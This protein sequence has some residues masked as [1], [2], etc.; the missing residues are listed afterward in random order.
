MKKIVVLGST[1]S[2]GINVLKVVERFPQQFSVVALSALNNTDLLARQIRQFKPRYAAIDAK[3]ICDLRRK[4]SGSKVSLFDT[5][6]EIDHLASLPQADIVVLGIEGSAALSPFLAAIRSGKHIAPANKEA[7]VMAGSVLMAEAKKYKA[8]IVP[9]DSEQS[10]IF[11][12]LQGQDRQGL[13]RVYLTASGGPLRCVSRDQLKRVSVADVLKHPRWRMGRKITVDSATLMNKG[14][15]VIEA[16]WLFDL[17]ASHIEVLIHPESIIHSMVEF[18][19]GAVMAQLGVTDMRIPIQYA[20]TYPK[21]SVAPLPAMDFIRQK[22]LTFLKP[23]VKKF[24]A[25]KLCY[26]VAKKGKTFGSVLNAANEEAVSAF[27]REKIPFLKVA[28]IAEK[29]VAKHRPSSSVTLKS[30]L[31]ADAW[32]REEARG[33]ISR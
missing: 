3:H 8:S 29:V 1:G 2:I 22:T 12:C 31:N 14:L 16:M 13:K 5:R 24:P 32:A 20:L 15:E 18:Q 9:V 17:A 4:I 7:L 26:D 21:R 33:L 28:E 10:A 23:D 25:L 30:I 6:S 27:L 11:Q 19:D